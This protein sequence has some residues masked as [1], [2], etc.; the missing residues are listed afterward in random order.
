MAYSEKIPGNQESMEIISKMIQSARKDIEDNS[1][2]YLLWGW[3][4]LI[5][6]VLE[7]VLLK[8]GSQFHF[9]GWVILMPAGAIATSVYGYKQEKR[10]KVKSF[11]DDVIKYILIAFLVVLVSVLA[12]M[13]KL[14]LMT[15][16]LILMIY[17]MWLFTSGGIIQFKPLVIGGIINWVL[18]VAAAFVSFENQIILLALAVLSGY[19][20]PGYMLKARFRQNAGRI[21]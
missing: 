15:Y 8:S 2:Y 3:L 7:Y 4:V 12:F 1:F 14:G 9:I 10:Q 18:A 16:P 6:C 13:S 21:K 5:A 19:I 20:A 11:I 17:G